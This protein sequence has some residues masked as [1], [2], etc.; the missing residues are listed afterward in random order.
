MTRP[1]AANSYQGDVGELILETVAADSGIAAGRPTRLDLDKADVE[2]ILPGEHF[3]IYTPTVKAQVKTTTG[4]RQLDPERFAYDLDVKTYDV[5]RRTNHSVSRV[6]VVIGVPTEGSVVK[7]VPDGTLLRIQAAWVSLEGAP[8]TK[9]A[10]QVAVHLP[11]RNT[12]D[13]EGLMRMLET[14]GVR[15]STP[16]PDVNPWGRT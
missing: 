9:N 15:R 7:I 4:L 1:P 14:H 10:T 16:V 6:L 12:I 3:G 13:R 8:P 11:V 2:L 5:L